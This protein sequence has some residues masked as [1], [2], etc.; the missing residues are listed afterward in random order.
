M[1]AV[2]VKLD[3]I[4]VKGGNIYVACQSSV[5]SLARG[6]E[7]VELSAAA[8]VFCPSLASPSVSAFQSKTGTVEKELNCRL[9]G[10]GATAIHFPPKGREIVSDFRQ[11]PPGCLRLLC[12]PALGEVGGTWRG[13]SCAQVTVA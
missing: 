11:I 9:L 3:S 4:D 1:T 5:P 6:R 2:T 13:C 10:P 7:V 8:G 12:F